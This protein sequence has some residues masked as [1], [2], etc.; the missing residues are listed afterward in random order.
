MA[1]DPYSTSPTDLLS[2]STDT[3][4]LDTIISGKATNTYTFEVYNPSKRALR[5]SSVALEKGTASLFRVN[6]DGVF[7]EGGAATGLEIGAQ[8]SL[9]V[10]LFVNAPAT[11]SDEP[12]ELSDNV[13]FTTEG[14][15][16]QRVALRA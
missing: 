6:V 7:L 9:R 2:F 4:N 14:G 8:D 3:V 10:F 16:V 11:D 1:D 12:V 13:V 15:A 5:L